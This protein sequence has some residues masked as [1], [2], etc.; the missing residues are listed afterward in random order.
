MVLSKNRY[1]AHIYRGACKKEREPDPWLGSTKLN[2]QLIFASGNRPP[3]G[4]RDETD[5][6]GDH[7][8]NAADAEGR[9]GRDRGGFHRPPPPKLLRSAAIGIAIEN[10]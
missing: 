8:A 3:G 9:L 7:P 1:V 6:H 5:Q 2:N 4:E 10:R